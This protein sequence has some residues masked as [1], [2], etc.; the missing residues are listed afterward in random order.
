MWYDHRFEGCEVRG[1][2]RGGEEGLLRA[3]CLWQRRLTERTAG[4][5][6]IGR[7]SCDGHL[8]CEADVYGAGGDVSEDRDSV[9]RGL[10]NLHARKAVHRCCSKERAYAASVG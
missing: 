9:I 1:V 3:R 6:N 4:V 10:R 7:V 8:S 5:R 2:E